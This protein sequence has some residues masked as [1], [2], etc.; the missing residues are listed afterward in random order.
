MAA[1]I[2]RSLLTSAMIG[3]EEA[4]ALFRLVLEGVGFE[5]LG[6][7][8]GAVAVDLELG[9]PV[10][11]ASSDASLGAEGLTRAV[12]ASWLRALW[13]KLG[14]GGWAKAG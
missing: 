9:H 10:V 13:K 8:F 1:R 12:R 14:P 6:I 2:G 11:L 5:T 4:N 3:E 7:P